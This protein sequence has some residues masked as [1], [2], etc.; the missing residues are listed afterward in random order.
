MTDRQQTFD[1][2]TPEDSI[3]QLSD[4]RGPMA[5]AAILALSRAVETLADLLKARDEHIA[6]LGE[7]IADLTEA[8]AETR[9]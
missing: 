7:I 1:T 8:Q 3:E 6:E 2:E 9:Q 4:L 5:G